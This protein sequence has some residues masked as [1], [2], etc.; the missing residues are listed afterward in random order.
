MGNSTNKP[1]NHHPH[2]P[3]STEAGLCLSNHIETASSVKLLGMEIA[4]YIQCSRS[5]CAG[6][7]GAV[8]DQQ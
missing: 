3:G 7:L 5:P 1:S 6:E 2:A 4:D 8:F